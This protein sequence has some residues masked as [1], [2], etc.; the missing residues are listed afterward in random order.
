MWRPFRTAISLCVMLYVANCHEQ[1]AAVMRLHPKNCGTCALAGLAHRAQNGSLR[2]AWALAR[3]CKKKSTPSCEKSSSSRRMFDSSCLMAAT[4]CTRTFTGQHQAKR[5]RTALLCSNGHDTATRRQAHRSCMSD[6]GIDD[7][8]HT[9][10]FAHRTERL[11]SRS[12]NIG[13][14]APLHGHQRRARCPACALQPLVW[15]R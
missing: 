14:F 7:G 6:R 1:P 13:S 9:T 2:N 10:K 5:P 3:T 11:S 15:R 12:E 8:G 4:L